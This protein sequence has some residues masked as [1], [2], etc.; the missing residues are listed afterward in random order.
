[1]DTKNGVEVTRLCN[2]T[3]QSTGAGFYSSLSG[4]GK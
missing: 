2:R 1:M 3:I 4:Q